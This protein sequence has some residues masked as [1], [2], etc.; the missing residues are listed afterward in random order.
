MEEPLHATD[1]QGQYLRTDKCLF[2]MAEMKAI[3]RTDGDAPFAVFVVHG[4]L[5]ISTGKFRL[6][7]RANKPE[8]PHMWDKTV[9]GHVVSTDP[10]LPRQAFDTAIR[11]EL[12]E[13]LGVEDVIIASDPFAFDRM[14]RAEPDLVEQRAVIRLID[15]EPWMPS[16]RRVAGGEPWLKRHNVC[17]YA[18]IYDGPFQFVDGEAEDQMTMDREQLRMELADQPWRYTDDLRWLMA[19][20][21]ALFR[22]IP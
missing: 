12:S 2:L 3:S 20:Y 1:A 21:F 17:V 10:S 19:R 5:F 15:Y 22:T 13:E 11:Q 8:N 9:G 7:Q 18:G 6:V 4:M 16:L 14:L